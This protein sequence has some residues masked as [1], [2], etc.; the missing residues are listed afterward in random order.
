MRASQFPDLQLWVFGSM[1]STEYPRDLDVLIIYTQPEQVTE[2]YAARL[3]EAT[4]PPLHFI[5]MTP[6]EEYDYR[7]IEV[8]DAVPLHP[9][10]RWPATA[11]VAERGF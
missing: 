2:L 11:P 3:W 7:F 8:T 10:G 1:L 5:A 4:L 9:L 6:D